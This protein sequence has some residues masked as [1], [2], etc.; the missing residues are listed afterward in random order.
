VTVDLST[1]GCDL[2]LS[3]NHQQRHRAAISKCEHGTCPADGELQLYG[4]SGKEGTPLVIGKSALFSVT[5]FRYQ[6][7]RGRLRWLLLRPISGAC[8]YAPLSFRWRPWDPGGYTRAS[9]MRGGCPPYLMGSKKIQIQNNKI[10]RDVKGLS[11]RC[12]VLSQVHS[13]FEHPSCWS[14]RMSC[15]SRRGVVSGP[16]EAHGGAAV[17]ATMGPP[18]E[19]R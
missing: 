19:I 6:P 11:S 7:P 17:A 16:K 3:D 12:L 1:R 2:A 8:P 5:T 10:S 14:S 15:L 18:R 13:I 4:S 9:P